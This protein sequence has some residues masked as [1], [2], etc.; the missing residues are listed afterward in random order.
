M[1][2]A[3][4][5][6]AL[7]RFVYWLFACVALLLVPSGAR[8]DSERH[9]EVM[10]VPD[11]VLREIKGSD[12]LQSAARQAAAFHILREI[13]KETAGPRMYSESYTPLEQKLLFAY[14]ESQTAAVSAGLELLEDRGGPTSGFDSPRETWARLSN[15]YEVDE[16]LKAE[17][18]EKLLP[19]GFQGRHQAML[20]G[21]WSTSASVA[22]R[23][24]DGLLD[25]AIWGGSFERV[26]NH[27][28][29]ALLVVALTGMLASYPALALIKSWRV[30]LAALTGVA[31]A[32][33]AVQTDQAPI[34]VRYYS[35]S[36]DRPE[37]TH[38]SSFNGEEFLLEG[39]SG[40]DRVSLA[41]ASVPVSDGH[42]VTVV[43]AN[44]WPC[45]IQNH[46][47]GERCDLHSGIRRARGHT[48]PVALLWTL[49]MCAVFFLSGFVLKGSFGAWDAVLAVT[50]A[51]GLMLCVS[52]GILM[53]VVHAFGDRRVLVRARGLGNT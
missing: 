32:P 34:S 47:T 25:G 3:R 36:P 41:D 39:A 21:Y 26:K 11:T 48:V 46:S 9:L 51:F 8:A 33:Q 12:P 20:R 15:Q 40:E 53:R 28:L 45:Y 7:T 27:P 23:A 5:T 52:G 37:A 13:V 31:R 38:V 1:V 17:V 6:V 43:W 42:R 49:L 44:G 22:P 2:T 19:P 16:T 24:G 29:G 14:T 30:K 10:P 4:G 18:M 35:G 50:G